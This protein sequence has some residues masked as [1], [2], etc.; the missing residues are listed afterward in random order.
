M[1]GMRDI[2]GA[3]PAPRQRACRFS[4]QRIELSGEIQL[5]QYF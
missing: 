3:D 4:T 2:F 1:R 5:A